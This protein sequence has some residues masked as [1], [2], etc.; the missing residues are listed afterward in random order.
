MSR[1]G[2]TVQCISEVTDGL[3]QRDELPVPSLITVHS[4]NQRP[5]GTQETNSGALMG[6]DGKHRLRDEVLSE[7]DHPESMLDDVT[8]PQILSTT[9]GDIEGSRVPVGEQAEMPRVK[10]AILF[11][12]MLLS[13]S[14]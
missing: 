12:G 14:P 6:P 3:C 4:L 8:I 2:A 1:V 9:V 5:M 13:L 11:A 7:K 10:F